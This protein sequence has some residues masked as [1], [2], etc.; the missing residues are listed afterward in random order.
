MSTSAL[1]R[2]AIGWCRTLATCTEDPPATTRT[3]LS[4]PMREVHR[5]LGQWMTRLG[6]LVTVDA[7]GNLRGLRSSES[8]RAPS[9]KP[10][11]A[12]PRLLVGSHLDTVPNAGAF[13]GVLGV[14][15][16]IALVEL[17]GQEPLPFAIEVVGLS[18]EEGARHGVPFIGS[19]ALVGTV[20]EA[21]LSCR[22]SHGLEVR[23]VIRDYGLDPSR[24]DEARIDNRA[25]GYLELHI[26][27]GPVLETLGLPV[28]IVESIAGQT[29]LNVVFTGTAGHAGTT[30]MDR[31]HDA[32]AGAAE[33]V[34]AVEREGRATHGLVATVGQLLVEPGA[35]N[36]IP[37]RA[38]ASL[39]VRH[40]TDETRLAAVSRVV[41]AARVI[42]A[43]RQ[44]QVDFEARFD[45]STVP[46]H[47]LF[48]ALLEESVRKSG[49][50]VHRMPSGAGHDAMVM[51]GRLR[52]A[53][54]FL[55]SPA[56]ISHHPDESVLEE[57]VAAALTV[58]RHFLGELS[59]STVWS[60]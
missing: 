39:D 18:D 53:M 47:P 32:L 33:W 29:R 19:R 7:A 13:D 27:Q 59:R 41:N 44:L 22:D 42:A 16:A 58:A 25:I 8:P 11:G 54:L 37:G 21:L 2:E 45:Q 3:F 23:D 49:L 9:S 38:R 52:A 17:V 5:L 40:T 50:P 24:I 26:E 57:D 55:R 43:R 6:M 48:I 1:A 10:S 15:M 35:S 20:D 14:V 46:M 31:R 60:I 28:A 4:P 34:D 12:P 36:V 51:A 30:P 56:G